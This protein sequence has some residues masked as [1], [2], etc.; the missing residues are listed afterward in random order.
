MTTIRKS[1]YL[2]ASKA[3]VWAFLTEVDKV[4]TWFHR[5]DADLAQGRD[6]KIFG[7]DSGDEL[8]HGTVIRAD[9]HDL[10][11]YTFSI[12]PMQGAVSTVKW[13]LEAVTGGTRLDLEHSGL[14][15]TAE[16]FALV[17]ALDKGWDDHLGRMRDPVAAA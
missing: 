8:G 15:D 6:Y 11:E 10:L 7:Q 17:L 16:G 12:G 3:S 14:S 9:P 5:Y 13:T 4:R 2:A 1:I